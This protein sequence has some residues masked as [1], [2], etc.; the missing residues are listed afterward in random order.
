MHVP[1]IN[2][3]TCGSIV[4]LIMQNIFFPMGVFICQI[5]GEISCVVLSRR[6]I[7]TLMRRDLRPER[8]RGEERTFDAH[9]MEIPVAD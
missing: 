5:N 2:Q 7:I 6:K 1:G 9:L 4:A 8:L 3:N